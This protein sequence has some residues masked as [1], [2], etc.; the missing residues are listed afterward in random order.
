MNMVAANEYGEPEASDVIMGISSF[1]V[2]IIL[3]GLLSLGLMIFYIVHVAMNKKLES[4]EQVVWI[5]L[6][7]FFGIIAFPIYWIIRVWN[8]SQNP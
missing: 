7:V 1:V 5:L 2:P 4:I 6:F 8:T 3:T